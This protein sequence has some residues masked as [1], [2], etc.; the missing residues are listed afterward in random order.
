MKI[1]TAKELK[2]LVK[3]HDTIALS[4]LS[5]GNLPVEILKHLIDYY[6]ETQQLD[7][8]TIMIANDISDYVGDGVDLDAFIKRNMIKRLI[9]SIIVA[10]PATITAIKNNELEAYFLPQGVMTT[11]YRNQTFASPGTITTIGLHTTVD[12]RYTGGKANDRTSEDL[13]QLT[14]VNGKEYLFYQFPEVDVAL[15]RGTYADRQGNIYMDHEAH[16]SEAYSV[17]LAAHRNNGKVI[18]Q[19][20]AVVEDGSFKPTD[21]FIPSALV[22][23]VMVNDNP[24]YHKQVVQTYYDPALSG[25]YKVLEMPGPYIKMSS[26]KVILRRAAQFLT[27]GDMVSIGFGI[28]N[29]LSNLLVEEDVRDLV[30]LNIDTGVFDGYIG[31]NDYLSMHYNLSARMRHEMTWDFIYNGGLDIAYLSFAEIDQHGNVNVSSYGNKLNG[32]GGFIDISQTV[33]TI[34][35]S[36][37]LVVGGQLDCV[38]NKLVINEEGKATKFADEVRNVDFNAEYA[39]SKGQTVYYVTE[40]AVFQL[41]NSGLKLIEIAPG[42]DID[43]DILANMSFKPIVPDDIGLMDASMFQEH[44]GNLHK[45]LGS[46]S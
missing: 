44:W 29:E 28:N 39:L 11:N 38:H 46:N 42:V 31:S 8:L 13:V 19:V 17:A 32:C 10:S 45:S 22:D 4:A 36:G 35:F 9:S 6:D 26:R 5:V 43:K 20:K 18:V 1:I 23:Y 25:H 30:H 40:R 24:R 27:R 15:L 16:L 37:S 3:S 12:P 14:E 2:N 7:N 41:T 34:V 33:D 21:V